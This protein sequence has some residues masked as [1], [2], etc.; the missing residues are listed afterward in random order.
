[1]AILRR[2]E[3]SEKLWKWRYKIQHLGQ[4]GDKGID[5]FSSSDSVADEKDAANAA[6]AAG[7][8]AKKDELGS[9]LAVKT[10]YEGPLSRD[11][12][13]DWV[14]Y[15]PKQL[16]KS[17]AKAQDRVAIKVFKIKDTDKPVISGRASLR[18]HMIQLQN[19]PLI[20]ALTT[21]LQKHDIHLDTTEIQIFMHP[22]REL[23]FAY[24]DIHA[25]LKSTP[26][27]SPVYSPLLL[28]VKLL[29]D[30]FAD[31]RSKLRHLRANNLVSFKLAWA[32]FPKKTTVISWGNNCELL[33]KV[34]DTSY[35]P[36]GATMSVLAIKGKVLRFNGTGFQWEEVEIEIPQF[37]GNMPVSKLPAY[38]LEFYKDKEDVV[39]RLT[40]RGRRVLGY[41]GLTYV[42]Y[43]GIAMHQEGK[44]LQKHN[45]DG[46][47][48]VDVMGYNKHHLAQGVREGTDPLTKQTV[49][50]VGGEETTG[51]SASA[52]TGGTV[53]PS[54]PADGK[55]TA[56][57]RLSKEAQ[58]KNAK[59]M[60]ALEE[61][62]PHLMYMLPLIEGYAL[63][64]KLWVSFY[65]EDLREMV[66]NDE[67]YDHLVYDE[68]QKD[69]VMSFVEN[70]GAAAEKRRQNKVLQD[71][72][73][74]KGEGLILLLSGPP[75]TGKTLMAEA[76]ADRTHRPLFYLQAEDLG[77]NAAVLGAN[78]KKVFE[79]ATEWDAVILLDEAD[80]FMA[81]RH[82]QDI[83]RNELVS[84]FL[85]ELE[86]YRGVIFLTTNLYSTIDSAFRSRVSLHLLFNSLT[87]DARQLVW[88]KF[89]D[90]LPS[91]GAGKEKGVVEGV[92][93]SD[94]DLKE[95][96][97]WQLNGREIKT[98]V[99]M[100]KSWC[101][102]KGY[103]MTLAR[104]ENGIKVTSPHAT[105]SG[106]GVD[107][108]LYDE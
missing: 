78:I 108:S 99:K 26:Q 64:N 20:S 86:Y 34:D 53:N 100:T 10:F 63:K 80:V 66:W 60:L 73:A 81:E 39:R 41:Q 98:A 6:A 23:F 24:D 96:A 30:I 102:H 17:A 104:L 72:I 52:N 45:V 37:G 106:E 28:F 68:Q 1:M 61:K 58:E 55:S 85:R 22:F 43:T 13:F 67:A 74:G 62:E 97:G 103:E 14:D 50:V 49:V 5:D 94:E 12:A 83:A 77:I 48:L 92:D 42:N 69:L 89:L 57:K 70:H 76:V 47:V 38:P 95:L 56:L 7:A 31:T 27:T 33:C 75:G 3:V 18:Y 90:R 9:S 4:S 59:A 82:P 35:K 16:S 44:N 88:R 11:G 91:K 8:T 29:D 87:P 105:K 19:N 101:E 2:D 46:R 36:I 54:T 65:V 21:I 107:T 25:T 51:A 32:F 84:I 71:V 15:P 93:I 79:M 40:E